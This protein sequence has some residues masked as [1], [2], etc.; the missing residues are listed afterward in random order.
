MDKQS[1]MTTNINTVDDVYSDIN[2]DD[3]KFILSVKPNFKYI[4]NSH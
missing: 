2:D 3:I 1:M 4:P